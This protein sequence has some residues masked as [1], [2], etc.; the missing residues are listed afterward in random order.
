[1]ELSI[2]NC[3]VLT[4]IHSNSL[5]HLNLCKVYTKKFFKFQIYLTFYLKNLIYLFHYSIY[6]CS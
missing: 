1:M 3:P 6:K 5:E 2:S 4:E